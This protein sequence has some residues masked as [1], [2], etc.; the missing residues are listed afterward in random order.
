MWESDGLPG[1]ICNECIVKLDISFQFKKQCE[2]ADQN[3]RQ[4]KAMVETSKTIV[5]K[6]IR[7]E[8]YFDNISTINPPDLS[9]HIECTPDM[10]GQTV[11][12]NNDG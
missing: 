9:E 8:R 10:S 1:Q 5:R 7:K 4:Y 11:T 6:R 3:L 2:K 12:R